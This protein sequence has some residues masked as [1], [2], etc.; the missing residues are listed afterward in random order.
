MEEDTKKYFN[1][2]IILEILIILLLVYCV[3]DNLCGL[4]R[5]S[6]SITDSTMRNLLV[7]QNAYKFM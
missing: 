2:V 1:Y 3:K 4:T 6:P 7:T 5:F